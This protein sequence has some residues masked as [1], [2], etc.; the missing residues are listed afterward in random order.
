MSA[1]VITGV[2]RSGKSYYSVREVALKHFTWSK[3]FF[4][5]TPKKDAPTII[6]NLEDFRLPHVNFE[7][8]LLENNVDYREFFTLDY[9]DEFVLPMFGRVV[10]ILDE[11]QS[12]FPPDFKDDRAVSGGKNRGR[13]VF[14]FF[15]FH[16]HRPIDI[17]L[18]GQLWIAFHPRIVRLGEYQI[19]AQPKTLSLRKGE[20]TYHFLNQSQ[21]KID[22][23]S[24]IVDPKIASLYKSSHGELNSNEIRPKRKLIMYAMLLIALIV[25]M[26]VF[27]VPSMFGTPSKPVASSV[28]SPSP[29]KVVSSPKVKRSSLAFSGGARAMPSKSPEEMREWLDLEKEIKEKLEPAKLTRITTGGAWF[30]GKLVAINLFGEIIRVSEMPYYYEDL[31]NNKISVLVPND[32]LP[33]ARPGV[34]FSGNESVV[35]SEP[36]LPDPP[37]LLKQNPLEIGSSISNFKGGPSGASESVAGQDGTPL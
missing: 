24:F 4:E 31:G 36:M 33:K 32:L 19:D 5:W 35:Q 30:G 22:S 13:S 3:D 6:T 23:A 21:H 2:P 7:Q 8:F 25:A 10:I 27:W 28:G 17:Y 11:A 29:A 14:F 37:A 12:Y 18:I 16:G 1:K 20:L 34:W 26:A 15:E 9:F